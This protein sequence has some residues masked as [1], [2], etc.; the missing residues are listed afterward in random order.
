MKIVTLKIEEEDQEQ[1]L[2]ETEQ[3]IA[4]AFDDIKQGRT[5]TVRTIA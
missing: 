1:K 3:D 2:K 4:C 5:K